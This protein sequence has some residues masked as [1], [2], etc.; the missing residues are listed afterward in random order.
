MLN[1][2]K[3]Q[4]IMVDISDFPHIR[5]WFTIKQAIEVIKTSLPMG[6]KNLHPMGTLVF[7]EQYNLVGTLALKDILKALEPRF[8]RATTKAEGFQEEEKEL[9]LI[10]DSLFDKE[11]RGL[12]EK[13]IRDSVVPVKYFV[14][15][16]DP[17]TK[18]AYLMVNQ[19]LTFMPV[20]E[21]GKKFVGVV[22]LTDVFDELS[23]TIS[24][25]VVK[26]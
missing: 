1:H 8:M 4:D 23:S 10:W 6:E 12:V 24:N 21:D 22:R 9:S 7:D 2:K 18:A 14:K 11:S 15:P 13:S 19:N 17:I 16:D 5:Y 3:V 25:A 26:E 20:L